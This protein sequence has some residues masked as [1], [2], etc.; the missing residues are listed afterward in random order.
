LSLPNDFVEFYNGY[1]DKIA[2]G[3]LSLVSKQEL[4]KLKESARDLQELQ[5]KTYQN[6]G[7]APMLS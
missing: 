2:E 7:D 6:S 5:P 3:T 1:L 4:V